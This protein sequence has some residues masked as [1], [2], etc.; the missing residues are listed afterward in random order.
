[1]YT[2]DFFRVENRATSVHVMQDYPLATLVSRRET[3]IEASPVPVLYQANAG[4]GQLRFHLARANP[5]VQALTEGQRVLLMF[6]G[7]HAYVSPSWYRSAGVPTWN[8][9]AIHCYGCAR[10]MDDPEALWQLLQQ[11]TQQHE[12]GL[13][14]PW[15]PQLPEAQR[16]TLLEKIVGFELDIETLEAKY[17]L[18][19]N[20]SPSDRAG[21]IQGLQA[22][23]GDNNLQMARWI[24]SVNHD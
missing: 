19:Q 6:H 9:I 2:P 1:M 12:R 23:G 24:E 3:E 20:R 11:Q 8:Y 17:K 21:V 14:L 18:S 15:V 5:Q 10:V 13:T 7:P 22:R 16:R 4:A